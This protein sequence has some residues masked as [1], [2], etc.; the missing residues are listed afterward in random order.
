VVLEV[1]ASDATGQV[2]FKEE[3]EYKNVGLNPKGEPVAAAWV[4]DSYSEE[5]STAF[6]PY[7]EKKESFTIPAAG[8][9]TVRARIISHHGLPI[10]FGQPPTGMPVLEASRRVPPA[11]VSLLRRAEPR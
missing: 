2:V 11:A 6:R 4:I 9:V 8:P 10:E 7:E 5:L 1:T 3:K